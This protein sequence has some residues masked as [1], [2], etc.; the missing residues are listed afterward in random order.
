MLFR[1]RVISHFFR[2]AVFLPAS[3]GIR[4]MSSLSNVEAGKKC[5]AYRAVDEWLKVILEIIWNIIIRM[6][7]SLVSEVAQLL[8]MQ[9]IGYPSLLKRMDI[10]FNV[11]QLLFKYFYFL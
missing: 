9:L 3:V 8:F 2:Q 7:K 10:K 1:A 4:E 5:A 11:F 6:V